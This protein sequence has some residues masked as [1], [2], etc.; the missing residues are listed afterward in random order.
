MA[1]GGI[2]SQ[3]ATFTVATSNVSAAQT[4]AL[5][6]YTVSGA[7]ALETITPIAGAL[8]LTMQAIGTDPSPVPFRE[9]ASDTGITAQL[10][11]GNQTIDLNPPSNG[12][13]FGLSP[14]FYL[15]AVLAAIAIAPETVDFATRTVPILGANGQTN[16]LNPGDTVTV[17]IP[18]T[19]GGLASFFLSNYSSCPISASAGTVSSGGIAAPNV[20]I[21]A[22]TFFC[23]TGSGAPIELLPSG[24]G[25][26]QNAY[27]FANIAL[28]PGSSTDFLATSNV[29]IAYPGS[30]CYTNNGSSCVVP[31]F[32]VAA[33]VPALSFWGMGAL[34]GMLLLF[35][36]RMLRTKQA[37]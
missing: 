25:S 27:G 17:V 32:F 21:G 18:G 1:G 16:A 8:P 37:A 14:S 2:G 10:V 12:T 33:P 15:T 30:I 35:G 6:T 28:S 24:A 9:F 4:I 29:S 31:S 11:G 19:Y 36:A 20:P 34:A 22:E 13:E 23:V 26:S 5:G 7:T 3:S